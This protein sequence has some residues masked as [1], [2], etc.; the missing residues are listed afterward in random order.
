MSSSAEL[1]E[2]IISSPAVQRRA[3]R[4]REGLASDIQAFLSECTA[5]SPGDCVQAAV[6]YAAY[7]AWAEER[8]RPLLSI[9]WFSQSLIWLDLEK[10]KSNMIWWL[11][12][13]LR[14]QGAD[15]EPA[16]NTEALEAAWLSS[17]TKAQLSFLLSK[18]NLLGGH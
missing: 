5:K 7:K 12:L 16:G 4:L 1:A 9:V 10:Y 17:S 2:R 11:D 8:G 13:R 6:L 14:D 15:V 18:L 3:V